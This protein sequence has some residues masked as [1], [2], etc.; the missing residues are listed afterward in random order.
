MK[1]HDVP[2]TRAG[3]EVKTG[4]R[5]RSTGGVVRDEVTAG[6]QQLFREMVFKSRQ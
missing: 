3:F 4:V 2:S 6:Q 5:E 1:G